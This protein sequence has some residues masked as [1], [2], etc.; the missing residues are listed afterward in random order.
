MVTLKFDFNTFEGDSDSYWSSI[1]VLIG[2]I[3]MRP[4]YIFMQKMISCWYL[5]KNSFRK[6]WGPYMGLTIPTSMLQILLENLF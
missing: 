6:L 4:F 1:K 3:L 5:T 2:E